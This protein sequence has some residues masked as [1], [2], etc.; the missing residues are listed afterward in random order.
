MKKDPIETALTLAATVAASF[1]LLVAFLGVIAI[2]D[3][4]KM[5]RRIDDLEAVIAQ[6]GI[7]VSE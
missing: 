2:V 7:E 1:V 3:G 5:Q 4:M 6:H